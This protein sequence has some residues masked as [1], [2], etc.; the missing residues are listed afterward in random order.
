ML[1]TTARLC[2]ILV[3]ATLTTPTAAFA[4]VA[5]PGAAAVPRLAAIRLQAADAAVVP[6]EDCGCDDTTG[7]IMMNGVR[8]SGATLRA[9]ELADVSGARRSVGS[10]IGEDGKAIVVFLRHLG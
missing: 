7:S 5:R 1:Y 9:T 3:V 10:M 2:A 4:T 6:A 8:V